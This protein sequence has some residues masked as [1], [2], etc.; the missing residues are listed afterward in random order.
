[1]SD[2]IDGRV[3]TSVPVRAIYA[4]FVTP[5][6]FIENGK[7]VGEPRYSG[8]FVIPAADL[9]P[10]ADRAIAVAKAKWPARELAELRWPWMKAEKYAEQEGKKAAK[11]GRTAEQVA[12]KIKEAK[13]LAPAGTYVMKAGSTQDVALGVLEKNGSLTE[14]TAANRAIVGKKFYHGCYVFVAVNLVPFVSK[15]VDDPDG[16]TAYLDGVVFAKDGPKNGN[17]APPLSER[18]K[19]HVGVTTQEDPTAGLDDEI[20]F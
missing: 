12:A 19:K 8:T 10:L 16:I 1:M 3:E 18:F 20:P 13:E 7:E 17:A 2:R 11:K 5:K 15:K 9:K 14:A 6:K 4:T